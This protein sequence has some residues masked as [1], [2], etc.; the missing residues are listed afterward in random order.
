MKFLLNGVETNRTLQDLFE[1]EN[2]KDIELFEGGYIYKIGTYSDFKEFELD[3]YLNLWG[4]VTKEVFPD[5]ILLYVD[6]YETF[7]HL[8]DVGYKS[9]LECQK[10]AQVIIY[11]LDVKEVYFFN[12]EDQRV[13]L[14]LYFYRSEYEDLDDFTYNEILDVLIDSLDLYYDLSDDVDYIKFVNDLERI[15]Y[16]ESK[17]SLSYY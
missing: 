9:I 2:L 8:D 11:V 10:N 14:D 7:N 13:C 6:L 17:Y 15:K 5:K 1:N 12:D 4:F 3:N 16:I